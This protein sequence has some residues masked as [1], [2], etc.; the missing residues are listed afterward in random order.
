MTDMLTNDMAQLHRQITAVGVHNIRACGPGYGKVV[1]KASPSAEFSFS[2]EAS[3]PR[4]S[5][6]AAVVSCVVDTIRKW[7]YTELIA[8]KFLLTE[9]DWDDIRSYQESYYKAACIATDEIMRKIE[10]EGVE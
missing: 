1:L 2:S 6:E 9:I 7:G 4:E 3:W 10:E 8:W 5:Y